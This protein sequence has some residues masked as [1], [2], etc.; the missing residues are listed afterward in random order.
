MARLNRWLQ[1]AVRHHAPPS[2]DGRRAKLRYV[3][4]TGTR[5]PRFVLFGNPPARELPRSYLRYLTRDL[6]RTFDLPGIPVSFEVRA[7]DNPYVE[8]DGRTSSR[9]AR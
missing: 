1:E 7:A 6:R 4:P 5:P 3:T 9:A 2:V 8:G